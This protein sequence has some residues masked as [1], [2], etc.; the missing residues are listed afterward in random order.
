MQAFLDADA[1]GKLA[2]ARTGLQK[3]NAMLGLDQLVKDS[4]AEGNI[5]RIQQYLEANYP[6]LA[7]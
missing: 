4:L 1:G 6:T 2:L 3:P 5:L 7:Q